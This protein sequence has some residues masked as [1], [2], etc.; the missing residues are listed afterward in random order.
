MK[1]TAIC[2]C[3]ADLA[4]DDERKIASGRLPTYSLAQQRPVASGSQGG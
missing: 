2:N 3:A 4:G 1:A